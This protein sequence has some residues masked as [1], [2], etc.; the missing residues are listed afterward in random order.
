MR[1]YH[2]MGGQPAGPIDTTEHANALWEKRVDAMMMLL[3]NRKPP[4][5]TVDQVRRAIENLPPDAYDTMA[6][7]ERWL[8]AIVTVLKERGVLDDDEIEA[9][10]AAVRARSAA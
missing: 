4:L 7:Y 9:R 6:Y 5:F 8:F 2:D 3:T 1:S 10:V